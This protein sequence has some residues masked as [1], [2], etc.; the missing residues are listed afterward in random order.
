MSFCDSLGLSTLSQLLVGERMVNLLP[1]SYVMND[2]RST[3]PPKESRRI[4]SRTLETLLTFLFALGGSQPQATSE[5]R[6]GSY[7]SR[8]ATLPPPDTCLRPRFGF[9]RASSDLDARAPRILYRL[10]VAPCSERE[11]SPDGAS[12]ALDG[13]RR[14]AFSAGVPPPQVRCV[15]FDPDYNVTVL[16]LDVDIN[17][18]ATHAWA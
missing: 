18:C 9:R 14:L 11:E 12:L 17:L 6:L 4:S 5:A 2:G 3:Y 13:V 10:A 7:A 16:L 8:S 1:N 15:D